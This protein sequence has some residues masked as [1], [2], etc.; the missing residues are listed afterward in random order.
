MEEIT[1]IGKIGENEQLVAYCGIY[2]KACPSFKSGK[3]EGC[4]GDSPKCANG[5]KSCQVRPCCIENG[6]FTCADCTIYA[7]TKECKKYN[8]LL[9]KIAAWIESSDRSKA[10]ALIKEKG[11]PEF[12][13][14]MNDKNWV[15]FKTKD[16]FIN[17]KLGK[18]VNEK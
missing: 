4:R 7:S 11:L 16:T 13:A 17:K 1:E 10:I 9:L 12:T 15:I 8:P 5:Y 14:F 2:C 18:K 6:F 3:C